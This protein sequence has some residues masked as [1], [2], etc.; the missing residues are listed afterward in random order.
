M[1]LDRHAP[2]RGEGIAAAF[3]SSGPR[4]RG[5]SY[6]SKRISCWHVFYTAHITMSRKVIA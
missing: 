2:I 3:V 6:D 5:V 1:T 4:G